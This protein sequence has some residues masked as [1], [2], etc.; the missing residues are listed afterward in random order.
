MDRILYPA[1]KR[2]AA[3]RLLNYYGLHSEFD[4]P[5]IY[6]ALD[7]FDPVFY[8]LQR[9][10]SSFPDP[11]EAYRDRSGKLVPGLRFS[12]EDQVA[13]NYRQIQETFGTDFYYGYAKQEDL[14]RFFKE[15]KLG[16][17]A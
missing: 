7:Q 1:S 8:V 2:E 9:F 6:R 5:D 10:I 16:K 4:L 17:R 14:E 13:L 3:S 12:S 15:K 11:D